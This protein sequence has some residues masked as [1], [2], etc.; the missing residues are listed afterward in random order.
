MLDKKWYKHLKNDQH[1]LK[2]ISESVIY[3][4]FHMN[5]FQTVQFCL[6]KET[7]TCYKHV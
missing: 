1:W 5:N 7:V 6:C 3:I 4:L 2:P